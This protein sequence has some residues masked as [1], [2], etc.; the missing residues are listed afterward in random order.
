MK[1]NIESVLKQKGYTPIFISIE[2][3]INDLKNA[4]YNKKEIE[5]TLLEF[6]SDGG[7]IDQFISESIKYL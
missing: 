4:G 7:K 2:K 1:A 6:Y 3:S 5:S